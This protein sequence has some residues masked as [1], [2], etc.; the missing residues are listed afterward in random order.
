MFISLGNRTSVTGRLAAALI[1]GTATGALAVGMAAP[2]HA[3]DA[4]ANLRGSVTLNGAPAATEV[5][6]IDVNSGFRRTATVRPDG[7]FDVPSLRP[8]T[9]RIELQ[10]AEGVKRTDEFT[11]IAGQNA[12]LD[13]DF[14]PE[15]QAAYDTGE[16][17]VTGS[18]LKSF[19]GG[20]V[21]VNITNREIEQLPQNNRNF[22][23]F[24]DLAPG[25]QFVTGANGQSRLQGGAQ[26]SRTVNIFIDGVGQKDYV[27]KNGVTGQDSTQ[28][29]PFPQ[30]AVG[31]Y[32]VISSNYKAEFDQ[33]SSVAITAA[34]KSGTNEFHGEAFVDFTNQSLRS[35]T[36]VED[37]SLTREKSK[38]R[39]FQFGGALGGPIVKDLAH[40]FV[41]YEGKRQQVPVEIFPGITDNTQNLPASFAGEFGNFNRTFNEDLYFGKIDI[42][43][44]D[45]DLFE[46][47]LKV[48][49][50]TGEGINNG[51]N[52]RE[53]A[54]N[55]GIDEYRGLL[56]WEHRS[57]SFVNDLKL[58][59]ED[60]SW[61]PNPV[62]FENAS[63]FQDAQG[64]QIIR[65]GG[66]ANFQDKGQTGYGIQNDFTYFGLEG[67]SIKFGAKAK[68]V[69]LNSLSLI[70]TNPVFVYNT[71]YN[72]AA[73]NNTGTFNTSVPYQVQFGFDSGLGGDP[74]VT[75]KNF[76]LGLYVQDDWEI[77]DRLTLN[78]G[79][80]W[81]YDRT[82]QYVD[83]VT[84]PSAIQAV[85]PANY[86]NL[87]N[88]DY[89]I[90][91]YIS[92]GS[93]RKTFTGAFQPRIGFSYILD[94]ESS[95][96]LFGGFG[97]SYDR[98]QFD[99]IQQET[100]VGAFSTRTFRFQVPG[101]TRNTCV[102]S[103][104]CV[105]WDPIY[106]TE[107]GRTQLV[108]SVGPQGGAE[109]RFINND[110]KVPY[111][112]Q[113]SLGLRRRFGLVDGEVGYQH[114]ESRDGFA[115]LLGNRRPD[116]SFFAPAPANQ[117]SPFGFAPPG[118]GAIILGDN[119]LSTSADSAY[120]KLTKRYSPSSPWNV[121]ATY[122]YTEA[123]ENRAFGETFSLDFPTI[124]D[125][126][127]LRS[128]GVSRHRFVAAGAADLPWDFTL[129]AKVTLASPPYLK[130]FST[131]P[132]GE[133]IIL[134]TVGDNTERFPFIVTDTWALRQVDLALTKYITLGFLN[135]DA[136]I[137]LRVDAINVFDYKNFTNY[138]GNARDVVDDANGVFGSLTG[139]GTGGNPPRTF[140]FSAGFSF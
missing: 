20:E 43:P 14:T 4:N 42:L 100:S 108:N 30:L 47:S 135:E 5:V 68:W 123:E 40:F 69:E 38:T 112:D 62:L 41:T 3:Q 67:H 45:K 115:W 88:A 91:D 11:L 16:I 84:T 106:L 13:F 27:L 137:R 124:A 26:D 99:F 131:G 59:Y 107:E 129:S 125:Y 89:D 79:I 140:K 75:S 36:P 6:V 57:D 85:S 133:R 39:D 65:T 109:L 121:T 1:L 31:E 132:N 126:P 56:R 81:D 60:V 71:Q 51:S 28:G 29:N 118:R 119:G 95:F 15:E 139:L 19:E 93:Q 17:I 113:F 138:N 120:L 48:R 55:Q 111:S 127:T 35:R 63:V 97:R 90:N 73:M 34:T 54:V 103:P 58:T 61:S 9:Y 104:T 83:F 80:R 24:A 52:L 12:V 92:D 72:P 21:G 102:P 82:P 105:A 64:R 66:G 33:V 134:G 10:T 98:N 8:S 87:V 23:A 7:S 101:D 70:N 76:Q 114:I 110:L 96:V 22:L 44:T 53:T 77:T 37:A 74:V 136:R 130:G 117:D 2:A 46:A 25:V 78:L 94:E 32:R 128:S 116:G 122:T 18:R 86:P 50:E 49:I